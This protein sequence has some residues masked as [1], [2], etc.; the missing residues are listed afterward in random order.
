MSNYVYAENAAFITG[1]GDYTANGEILIF[2]GSDLT[3]EQWAIV[4]SLPE[5]ERVIY[6]QKV[7][8]GEDTTDYEDEFHG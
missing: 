1:D 7:L 5:T 2:E 8:D 6:A 3:R 4:A